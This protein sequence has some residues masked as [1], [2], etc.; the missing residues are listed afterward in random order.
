LK[1]S[2]SQK[3]AALTEKKMCL[4]LGVV[5]VRFLIVFLLVTWF[6]LFVGSVIHETVH[7]VEA[8]LEGGTV[9]EVC[10]VGFSS[11]VFPQYWPPSKYVQHLG[12]GWVDLHT[13]RTVYFASELSEA[14]AYTIGY[15]VA[16]VVWILL[17]YSLFPLRG[18]WRALLGEVEAV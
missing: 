15:G 17:M 13:P 16:A 11:E 9:T 6:S 1:V 14:R 10:Y 4:G 3:V 8:E 5:A 18:H 12:L 2:F 7:S